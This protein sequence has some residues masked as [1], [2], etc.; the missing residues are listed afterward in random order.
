LINFGSSIAIVIH[1]LSLKVEHELSC[2][3]G[4]MPNYH[5]RP[6]IGWSEPMRQVHADIDQ[7]GPT[8]LTVI[9]LGE[10]GTGKELVACQLHLKS[11]RSACP[12]IRVNCATLPDTL[13]ETELFGSEKGAFTGAE[14]RQGRFELRLAVLVSREDSIDDQA[15]K[16][17]R[18]IQRITATLHERH[19]PALRQLQSQQR[20][21]NRQHPLP[22]RNNGKHVVDEMRGRLRHFLMAAPYRA[23]VR[24]RTRVFPHKKDTSR[25]GGRRKEPGGRAH[26]NRSGHV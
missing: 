17:G 11:Q 8:E 25:A 16:V 26:T 4:T 23:C 10:R 2:T 6:L 20:K 5:D 18:E 7:T 13:V 21:W 15:V 9:I 12:Y 19:G 14:F 1:L 24:S 3:G 22:D